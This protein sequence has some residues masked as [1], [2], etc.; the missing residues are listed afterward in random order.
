MVDGN[1]KPY[2]RRIEYI[3][4]IFVMAVFLTGLSSWVFADSTF[5]IARGYMKGLIT[6]NSVGGI[7]PILA[8]HI[9]LLLLLLLYIPFTNMM[10]FFAKSFA[11]HL[12]RWDD[13]PNL[14]GSKLEKKLGPLLN[15][16]V[17]W[18]APHIEAITRWSDAVPGT[19]EE[20]VPRFQGKEE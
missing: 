6:F 10:H 8:A 17:S 12:V 19:V 7:E 20:H 14:R 3:N 4:L 15:Q 2:T 5:A 18:S 16:P 1:L 13:V 11:Y 9:L